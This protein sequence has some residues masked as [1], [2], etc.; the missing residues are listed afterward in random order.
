MSIHKDIPNS[1]IHEA[2][3]ASTATAGQLLTATGSG[4]ATFQTP[5][6]R[7]MG[8]WDY[9]DAATAGTPITLSATATYFPLTN[10]ELGVNTKKTF[11][12]PGVADVWDAST[13]RFDF[14]DLQIG[15]TVDIRIDFSVTTTGANHQITLAIELGLGAA[16]YTLVIDSR[17]VKTAGT[18]QVTR[19]YS[20]YIGDTNTKDNPAY[21][22]VQ[23][24]AGTTDTVVVNGWYMRV[25]TIVPK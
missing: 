8:W 20:I 2:K 14:S 10:D 22:K 4:T 7:Y 13:N 11:A 9:N 17:N 23:S 12:L 21:L 25:H 24:D 1:E 5:K 3:G 6:T 15:D 19:W 16:P 18:Y